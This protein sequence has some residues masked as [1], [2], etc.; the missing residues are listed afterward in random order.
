MKTQ[1]QVR[2]DRIP[3][4]IL[5]YG[6]CC[7]IS[8]YLNFLMVPLI[9]YSALLTQLFILFNIFI[10]FIRVY[11]KLIRTDLKITTSILIGLPVFLLGLAS[12][13]Y[14]SDLGTNI[15]YTDSG[16]KELLKEWINYSFLLTGIL[17]FI[18]LPIHNWRNRR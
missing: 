4:F 16:A 7:G 1:S 17:S 15:Q 12:F 8:L 18:F 5:I 3:A 2:Y 10:F 13:K 14:F 6:F 11:K 9:G